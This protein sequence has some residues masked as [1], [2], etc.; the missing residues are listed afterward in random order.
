[1]NFIIDTDASFCIFYQI[2]FPGA[3]MEMTESSKAEFFKRSYVAVDGLWFMKTEERY[4]FDIALDIDTE[5][6]KII[7]KIQVRY[8]KE[9][10]QNRTGFEA[11]LECFA[12]KLQLDGFQFEMKKVDQNQA[13]FLVLKC[14]WLEKLRKANREHLAGKIGGRICSTEYSGWAKEFGDTI[15]FKLDGQ[16]CDG[17]EKCRLVFTDK[18]K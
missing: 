1:L 14:P 5:V 6:W 16:L 7:Q 12:V 17:C 13:E 2:L 15:Q 9:L 8:L 3:I 4:N 11:L 18:K 10:I